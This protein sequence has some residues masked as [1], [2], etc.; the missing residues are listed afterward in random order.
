MSADEQEVNRLLALIEE[1]KRK[2]E[3]DMRKMKR[4]VGKIQ[5]LKREDDFREVRTGQN[6]RFQVHTSVRTW[7]DDC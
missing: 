3:P 6:A 2:P 4:M 5:W 7:R 1:E